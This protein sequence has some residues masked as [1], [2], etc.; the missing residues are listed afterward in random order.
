MQFGMVKEGPAVLLLS[1]YAAA[2][3]AAQTM[4]VVANNMAVML[5]IKTVEV[6][7]VEADIF[8]LGC[9]L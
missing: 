2:V 3:I 8:K 5:S 6:G 7:V 9:K 4:G 1:W